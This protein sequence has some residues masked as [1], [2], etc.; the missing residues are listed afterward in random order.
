VYIKYRQ[1]LRIED[2]YLQTLRTDEASASLSLFYELAID[3]EGL[4]I[5]KL[6]LDGACGESVFHADI[7]LR[8]TQGSVRIHVDASKLWWPLGRGEPNLYDVTATLSKDGETVD[9]H[10]FRRGIRAVALQCAS[11]TDDTGSGEFCFLVNGKKTFIFGS[12]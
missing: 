1:R 11:V 6:Q 12:N 4:S 7:P 3:E 2:C 9:T 8:F 10:A 5:Y